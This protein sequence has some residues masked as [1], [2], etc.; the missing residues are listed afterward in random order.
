M[1]PVAVD[2]AVHDT[3]NSSFPDP[4][5]TVGALGAVRTVFTPVGVVHV[6]YA[7]GVEVLTE[8][9]LMLY[10]VPS[11]RDEIVVDEPDTDVGALVEVF[12]LAPV[13]DVVQSVVW[14]SQY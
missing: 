13:P 6:E 10:L 2:T 3:V 8:R 5:A 11:E 7:F 9:T 14:F 12:Q 1:Y 4:C